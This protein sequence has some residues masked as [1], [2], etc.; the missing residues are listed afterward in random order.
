[1]IRRLIRVSL[2]FKCCSSAIHA[3]RGRRKLL[4]GTEGPMRSIFHAVEMI[5]EPHR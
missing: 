5:K 1:M 2:R 4:T 3:I